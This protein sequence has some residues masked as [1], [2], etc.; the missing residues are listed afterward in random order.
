MIARIRSDGQKAES[1][2]KMAEITLQRLD[3]TDMRLYPSNTLLDFYDA[4]HKL[5][6]A[7]TLWEGI[8][9]KGEGAH[10]ELI[11][12]AAKQ[13]RID[14]QTRQFLQQMREYRNRI[15]YEGFM[16]HQN[17]V[18]LNKE[19][20]QKIINHLLELLNRHSKTNEKKS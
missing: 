2:K 9:I 16:I 17:Y 18:D 15:S 10:Q 12:Y 4:I 1:L 14:E 5:V 20:I 3:K 13:N 6:E 8:K 19:K 11:D 7:L